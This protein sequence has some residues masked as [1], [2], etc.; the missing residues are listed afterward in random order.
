LSSEPPLLEV[1]GLEAAWG[2]DPVLRGVSFAIAPGE[3]VTLLG[4]N[5]S[6]KTTLLRCIAGL[7]APTSGT[8]R[9]QG[10]PLGDTPTHRR[11]IGLVSQENSLFPH[12]TVRENIAYGPLVQGTG[13]AEAARRLEE[14]LDLLTLR[15]LADR[16]PGQLSGGEQQRVALARALA[17]EPSVILLDEPFASVD[18]E[19]RSELRAE[20]HS[21][22]HRR[23]IAAIH[24]TH[25]REEG[26]FLADRT[27]VLLDGRLVQSGPPLE[28]FRH[29]S[30]APVARFLGY[31][32]LPEG[33]RVLAIDPHDLKLLEGPGVAASARVVAVGTTGREWSVHL[34]TE[35]GVAVEARLLAESAPAQVGARVG[36]RWRRALPLDRDGPGRR[37]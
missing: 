32:L 35:D 1:D 20:F 30:S 26:L 34:V 2:E 11:R 17:V 27:L 14:L 19:F 4:P 33:D 6:G 36:L 37:G 31:N 22:L 5:G 23:G 13:P 8:I 3:L 25:D 15:R 28:V 18:P 10:R 9:L 7:E 29:P 24:V 21:V 16:R 12:R